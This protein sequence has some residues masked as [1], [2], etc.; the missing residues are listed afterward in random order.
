MELRSFPDAVYRD[1][2]AVRDYRY[3][4]GDH[5]TYIVEPHGRRVIEEI[6]D[7]D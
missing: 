5:R 4:E 3:I 2:P 1:V 7:D 6:D